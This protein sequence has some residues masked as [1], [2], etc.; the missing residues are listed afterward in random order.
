MVPVSDVSDSADS[1]G[2]PGRPASGDGFTPTDSDGVPWLFATM[3]WV[4]VID[5]AGKAQKVPVRKE[6]QL[7]PV[8]EWQVPDT[9]FD[10][11]ILN[12][13]PDELGRFKQLTRQGI[14]KWK[15]GWQE[16]WVCNRRTGLWGIDIDNLI[17]FWARMEMLGIEP[18]VTWA[19][20]TGREGGGTHMLFDGR[21]LPE[22]YWAQGG[23]GDP[24]WGDLKCNGFIAAP[25]A[26]HPRG[27][28]YGWRPES[29][30]ILIKPTLEFAD[31][32]LD[33]RGLWKETLRDQARRGGSPT[34]R[35][36]ISSA[37]GENRNVRLTSLR[38]ALFNKVP[39]MADDEI[40]QALW[41][42]NEQF[43]TP[44]D[45]K[46]MRDTVLGPKPG[47]ERH[48][49]LIKP[50][51]ET[52]IETFKRLYDLRESAGKFYARPADASTPAIVTE[53]G[54]A[55]GRK[56]AAWWEDAAVAW[57]EMVKKRKEEQAE[58]KAVVRAKEE[59]RRAALL[60]DMTLEE[61]AEFV[62]KEQKA[63]F[64][65]APK[66]P[67]EQAEE[68]TYAKA[69]PPRE[70]INYCLYHLEVAASRHEPVELHL[71]VVDTPGRVVVDL[72]D[73]QARAVEITADGWRVCDIR[74]VGGPAWFRRSRP[75]LAQV[76]PVE[77]EDVMATLKSAQKIL[78][79]DDEAWALA[80]G[81]EIGWHFPSID[82][83]GLWPTG[84]SG[85][86]KTTRAHMLVNLIDPVKK[87]GGRVNLR[88]DER[89]ARAKAMSRYVVTMDNMSE[90]SPELS[91]WWCTLHTGVSDEVRQLHT[92]NEM[93]SFDYQR[94]GLATSLALPEG[95]Q[96]D[97]LRRTLHIELDASGV[98]P[99]KTTLWQDYEKLRPQILGAI[100]TV[101]SKVL[102][103]LDDALSM[104]LIGCPEM[105]DY[106]RRLK[107]ADLAFPKIVRASKPEDQDLELYEA[108]SIHTGDIQFQRGADDPLAQ[109]VIEVMSKH[110]DEKGDLTD[111]NGTPTALYKLVKT[112]A[113]GHVM[114]EN[115]VLS[116][117]WPADATK[118]GTELTKLHA[119][120]LRLGFDFTRA[121]SGSSRY[122]KITRVPVPDRD[123]QDS[124]EGRSE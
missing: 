81:A 109:L 42:A 34:G 23:L 51:T 78:G 111:F 122:Y 2:K 61:Q 24:C 22:K 66:E 49:D 113:E 32:I 9:Y 38:G 118:L 17:R 108:Y 62:R 37:T 40:E 29:G 101:I 3:P 70:Q 96:P 91:D 35:H 1:N 73:E 67:A 98:H 48:P 75:M 30:T 89:N 10:P 60:A 83:P 26:Q 15:P 68:D 53:I 74:D 50:D 47:W 119:P 19:Q 112:T 95:L 79:L 14:G 52:A 56:M 5:E 59:E 121:K 85:S 90:V 77:V 36:N 94:V 12:D 97:A 54:D 28:F 99:D 25:G 103:N 20:D 72:C 88:R 46:E 87:I 120:L 93:L 11:A 86:G 43:S 110:R 71:R 13:D 44:L 65:K 92:D 104:Q 6:W 82:R 55:F 18:P 58:E 114:S 116:K 102:A 21:D 69:H 45:E 124:S 27:P 105:A 100:Y 41:A 16:G 106:A 39:E 115:Y 64:A 123:A 4:G 8:G 7:T 76:I 63:L 33:E 80:L 107:A 117:K 31:V 84:P 57:N